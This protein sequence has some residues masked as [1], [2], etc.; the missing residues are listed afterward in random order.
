MSVKFSGAILACGCLLSGCATIPQSEQDGKVTI[1]HITGAIQCELSAV[2]TE[3]RF[4]KR[5]LTGWSSL[6]DLDLTIV[7]NAGADG[8]ATI[9]APYT[10]AQ[11]SA[12]PSLGVSRKDTSVSSVQFAAPIV[13]DYLVNGEPCRGDDPSE[14]KMG[15]AEWFRSTLVAIDRTAITGASFTKEFEIVANAGVRF[16]YTLTPV[17]NPV[18]VDAG[19]GGSYSR[20]NRVTVALAPPRTASSPDPIP[21]YQVDRPKTF[22]GMTSES[23]PSTRSPSARSRAVT[24]PTT[25]YLLQ[26]QSPVK[27]SR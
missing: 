8:R 5:N 13:K 11:V 23:A 22:Q 26:R 10:I 18:S 20:T 7:T 14:T 1:R 24:N 25:L 2:A 6:V 27:L 15:L 4:E 21:V 19:G 3:S 17:N 12:T 9:G 16:G